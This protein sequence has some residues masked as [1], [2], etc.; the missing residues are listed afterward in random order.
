MSVVETL[1]ASPLL[2]LGL[3]VVLRAVVAWQHEVTWPEYRT[4]H[5]LRRLVFPRLDRL[6]PFGFR[7]FTTEKGG[8]DDPEFLRTVATDVRAT[9]CRLRDGGGSL[10]LVSSVKRRP[11]TH[12]DPL[13][14]AHV[15]WTHPA[16]PAHAEPMQTEA[17]LFRNGDG[18]TDV[19]AH[20]EASVIAPEAH[21][22]T[23]Q[24]DGD[25]RGVVTAALDAPADATSPWRCPDCH[26]DPIP[27]FVGDAT[28]LDAPEPVRCRECG[29]RPRQ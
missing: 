2:V 16:T 15:V 23:V 17:Y 10:H 11:D 6:E 29:R 24:R 9:A 7:L 13:S 28:G 14:A 3:A 20:Y 25:P 5:G 12:G 4:L 18:T 27:A 21:L 22:T 26:D 19:Y 1:A 8:R